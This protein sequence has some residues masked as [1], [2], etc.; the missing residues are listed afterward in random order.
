MVELLAWALGG[1][2]IGVFAIA[3]CGNLAILLL[4]HVFKWRVSMVPLVGGCCGAVGA[5]VIPV[6]VLR[7]AW[8]AFLIADVSIPLFILTLL[9]TIL[10]AR[11]RSPPRE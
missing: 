3:A 5:A 8:W 4:G 7:S 1:A 9:R 11:R 6:A 10:S 2:L